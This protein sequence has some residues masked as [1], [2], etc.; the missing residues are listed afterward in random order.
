MKYMANIKDVTKFL[1][2]KIHI[3]AGFI[4]YLFWEGWEGEGW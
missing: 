1:I 3:F 2:I 4:I